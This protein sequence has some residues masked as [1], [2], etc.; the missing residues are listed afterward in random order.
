[1]IKPISFLLSVL[2]SAHSA[3]AEG[4]VFE[5]NPLSQF[6]GSFA[7][8]V[9]C[10]ASPSHVPVIL[11]HGNADSNLGWT[12]ESANEPS[13]LD[14][15]K[16]A[17]YTYCDI[18]AVS[19]L[20]LT[21]QLNPAGNYHELKK[22]RLKKD[23]IK[24]VLKNTGQ[25]QVDIVS[26]SLGVTLAL[27][28]LHRFQLFNSVRKFISIAGA[29]QGLQSCSSKGSIV[30]TAKTCSAVLNKK[31]F[32]FGFWP[33][34]ASGISNPRMGISNNGF[35][36]FPSLYPATL[37]YTISAGLSDEVI[38]ANQQENADSTCHQSAYFL[39]QKTSANNV[40]SQVGIGKVPNI[41]T[42]KITNFLGGD[43]ADGIGH[44][45]ARSLSGPI[46]TEMLLTDCH[47]I[48]CCNKYKNNSCIEIAK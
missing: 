43:V 20:S 32:E 26:H 34:L 6:V 41:F 23:Y 42:S 3:L 44:M 12:K 5:V 18:Y 30:P 22:M 7:G 29:M 2:F 9:P 17:G 1:M 19:Y 10:T 25:N 37:F 45:R 47:G 38:C 40:V 31:N 28:T 4:V 15:M 48:Q 24:A 39:N 8:G 16:S 13:F 36:N 33:D 46:V 14:Q 11:I 21:E 27:E 35:V